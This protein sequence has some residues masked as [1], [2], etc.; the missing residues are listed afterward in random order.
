[1]SLPGGACLSLFLAGTMVSACGGP[2]SAS[3]PRASPPLVEVA[4]ASAAGDSQWSFT[5]VV[6]ARI[7]SDLGFRV[8][9]KVTQRLV[10][11]GQTVRKGQPLMRIDRTDFVNAL[12]AQQGTF[13]AAQA[14]AIQTAADEARYRDLVSAGAVSASTYDQIKAA[15]DAAKAQADRKSVV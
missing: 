11:A 7:Q 12:T 14:R 8:A 3:D 10:D 9:G 13:G 6:S 1:M 4:T 2:N 5:G 15:A